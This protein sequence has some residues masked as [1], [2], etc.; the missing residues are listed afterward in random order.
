MIKTENLQCTTAS[1]K[2]GD[3]VQLK[4]E[5]NPKT[6]KPAFVPE[7][8]NYDMMVQKASGKPGDS[9][10]FFNPANKVELNEG[11]IWEVEIQNINVSPKRSVDGRVYIFIDV[12]ITGRVE[13]IYEYIEWGTPTGNYHVVELKS[14]S[15]LLTREAFLLA[16]ERKWHRDSLRAVDAFLCFS[17]GKLIH[18][19]DRTCYHR[20]EYVKMLIDKGL[21]KISPISAVKAFDKLPPLPVLEKEIQ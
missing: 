7:F 12:K 20:D 9:I 13:T 10:R 19:D 15:R 11:E 16:I 18:V 17:Q 4:V 2:K 1:L 8:E 14:G 6:H 3:V 21:G 5:I